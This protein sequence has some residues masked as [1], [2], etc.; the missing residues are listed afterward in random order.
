MEAAEV[1]VLEQRASA[2]QDLDLFLI[3]A[4]ADAAFVRDVLLPGLGLSC[5]RTLLVAELTPGA[6]RV[7]EIERGVCRSR[8]TVVVLSP[9]YLS[10]GWAVF[11]EALASHLS[12]GSERVI[13]LRLADCELPVHLD[14]RVALD[15]R[16]DADREFELG[17]L[18]RLLELPVV[19]LAP[20]PEPK[21]E[22]PAAAKRSSALRGIAPVVAGTALILGVGWALL[23]ARHPPTTDS[24]P[25]ASQSAVPEGKPASAELSPTEARAK[26]NALGLSYTPAAFFE[27]VLA[28]DLVAVNL[29]LRSGMDPNV[30]GHDPELPAQ[31]LSPLKVAATHDQLELAKTLLAAG[32]DEESAF[33]M[34]ALRGGQ[35]FELLLARSPSQKALENGLRAAA[36]YRV[37]K[38]I[39]RLLP[40]IEDLPQRGTA[41]LVAASKSGYVDGARLLLDAGVPVDAL[42]DGESALLY[43]ARAG[44][45]DMIELLLTRG[46]SLALRAANGDTALHLAAQGGFEAAG[47]SDA[48][49]ARA[50]L[51][52]GAD[53]AARNKLG[54]TPLVVAKGRTDQ[55]RTA[56]V[57]LLV[58]QHADVNARNAAGE[59]PLLRAVAAGSP[60]E[61]KLLL[62][63]G[64]KRDARDAQGTTVWKAAAALEP[65]KR[66]PV[67]AAL[68]ATG[69]ST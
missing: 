62:Q 47:L 64:A 1:E 23:H 59:S 10:D 28:N 36:G 17:R 18:R 14:F 43:A 40:L 22:P 69:T 46:A 55:D 32:A 39:E 16:S 49:A 3:Y 2:A 52:H 20:A 63:H 42:E 57:Q 33:Y 68:R 65:A 25:A 37:P 50:L 29:Y 21:G 12:I 66:K 48:A 13:P 4:R 45:A 27:R 54:E 19:P 34:A 9:A 51:A 11:G 31:W 38:V 7:R 67:L 56:L 6:S 53:I 24:Q 26:L 30:I 35:V 61:V 58:E 5:E 41:A 60:D 44:R 15:F 8:F